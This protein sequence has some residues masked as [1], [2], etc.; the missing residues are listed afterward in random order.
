PRMPSRP[1]FVPYPRPYLLRWGATRLW[2]QLRLRWR[3]G[4]GGLRGRPSASRPS[5]LSHYARL[6]LLGLRGRSVSSGPFSPSIAITLET[7]IATYPH[8]PASRG[9]VAIR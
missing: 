2:P 3:L 4:P 9:V 5:L 6:R 1:G 8:Q 7:A